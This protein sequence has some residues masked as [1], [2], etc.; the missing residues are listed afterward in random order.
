MLAW[1]VPVLLILLV[2]LLAAAARWRDIEGRPP[3]A[4]VIAAGAV[5]PLM[6]A[7]QLWTAEANGRFGDLRLSVVSLK[8]TPDAIDGASIGGD[9]A[10]DFLLVGD[11]PASLITLHRISDRDVGLTV[12][13]P[14]RGEIAGAVAFES[15]EPDLRSRLFGAPLRFAGE[16]AVRE[17]ELFCPSGCA[18]TCRVG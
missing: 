11:L 1:A 7:T 9:R 16:R 6:I 18:A 5:A 14:L 15:A 17:G 3:V 2:G 8:L 13:R 10:R 12:V 4:L